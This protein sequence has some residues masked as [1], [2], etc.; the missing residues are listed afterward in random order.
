M[1]NNTSFTSAPTTSHTAAT[2]LTN[3]SLVAKNAL[4]A[5]LIVSAVAASVIM[6]GA[7]TPR[8]NDATL[9]AADWSSAPMTTRSGFMKSATAEPSRR[10]SGFDTTPM[11]ER[12]RACSTSRVEPTGTVDLLTTTAPRVKCGAIWWAASSM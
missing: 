5:Y 12:A 2:A 9:V 4:L 6:I 1:P 3:D 11:S 10:N 7:R 8:Y